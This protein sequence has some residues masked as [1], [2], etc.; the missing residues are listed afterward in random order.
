MGRHRVL[1][2]NIPCEFPKIDG[3]AFEVFI[4][5]DVPEDYWVFEKRH[6]LLKF[7]LTLCDTELYRNRLRQDRF[8]AWINMGVVVGA[9]SSPF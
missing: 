7:F 8:R 5:N 4:G 1:H 3:K 6:V 2:R 9:S